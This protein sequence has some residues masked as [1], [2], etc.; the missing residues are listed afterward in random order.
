MTKQQQRTIGLAVASVAMAVAG[1][2]LYR[3]L[4]SFRFDGRKVLIVGGS[5]GLGLVMARHLAEQNATIAIAARDRDELV[6]AKSQLTS[7]GAEILTIG[8]DATDRD[9]AHQMVHQLKKQWGAIDVVINNAGV[10]QAG[11]LESMSVDDYY[12]AMRTHLYGPLYVNEAVIPEMQRRGEGRIVNISSIGGRI[13][14]PHLNPYCASK[15]ALVGYS[16]GLRSELAKD[17]IAVTTICP[18]LLRTGSPCNAIFKGQHRAEY[19]WFKISDSLPFISLD[20]ECAARQ[21]LDAC[22]CGDALVVLGSTAKLAE[23]F[24]AIFPGI[25]A[26]LLGWI[27]RL[28][29]GNCNRGHL[30]FRG[31][32]SKSAWSESFLTVLTDQAA[33][34]NNQL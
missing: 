24:N 29:P 20:A 7:L 16:L 14:V 30:E 18:G 23:K 3:R 12:Q 21:I 13:S 4:T 15:Y 19:A 1:R 33:L 31:A 22:R 28:L 26:D 5:R 32:E 27:N 11:P 10:I 8:C 34:R 2:A 9:A 6:R 25:T 17:G